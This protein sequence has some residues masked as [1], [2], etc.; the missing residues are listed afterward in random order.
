MFQDQLPNRIR[1]IKPLKPEKWAR[2][3]FGVDFWAHEN[4][5]QIDIID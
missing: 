2:E 4:I 3:D 5:T 1:I